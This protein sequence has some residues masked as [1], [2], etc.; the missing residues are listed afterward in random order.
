MSSHRGYVGLGY[1]T[2][3]AVTAAAITGIVTCN[4]DHS[5]QTIYNQPVQTPVATT[6]S[7][8]V[9]IDQI[10]IN[11]NPASSPISHGHTDNRKSTK[12]QK[13][14]EQDKRIKSLEETVQNSDQTSINQDNSASINQTDRKR[15]VTQ[16]NS[17]RQAV[18]DG[19]LKAG[20]TFMYNDKLYYFDGGYYNDNA[21]FLMINAYGRRGMPTRGYFDINFTSGFLFGGYMG[22]MNINSFRNY[23]MNG[24]INEYGN[25][26]Y[27]GNGMNLEQAGNSARV[28][29]RLNPFQRLVNNNRMFRNR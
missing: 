18:Y 13:D 11:I 4:R 12:S 19:K 20:D 2:V 6:P 16:P 23:N 28:T 1:F 7:T 15:Y 17:S 5:S 8:E 9:H 27:M 29:T 25:S 14:I 24:Y 26:M 10:N 3:A 21:S 22:N